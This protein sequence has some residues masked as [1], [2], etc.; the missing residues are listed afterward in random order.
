MQIEMMPTNRLVPY[1]RNARTHS[2]DQVAQIAASIAEFGFTNPILIGADEVII[3]GHGRLQAARSLG[4]TE[5]PVIVLDHLSEAQ[6]RALVIADNRI[7]EH[8]GWNEQLLAA[9]I[10]ALRD[11]AFDL[12]VIGFSEAEIHDLLDG[13]DDPAADGIGFGG[14]PAGSGD[15]AA[16]P[17]AAAPSITLAE[18]FGIPPFSVLDA[19]KG[20]WQDRKRAWLA[21]GIRSELGR[22]EGD[23][24]CP[25][26]SPLPGNGSRKD[27][28]P[29]AVRREASHG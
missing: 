3:A 11:E 5:V 16:A 25:G 17:A 1:I 14:Q 24:A 29:G 13:L 2:A 21:L 12:E 9:E 7:A 22:G 8:A 27:Y 6:R 23:R 20:W 4:L 28:L 19:R 15:P 18:R 10:A 26:G